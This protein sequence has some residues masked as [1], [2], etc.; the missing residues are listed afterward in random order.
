MAWDSSKYTDVNTRITQF[1][2]LY[3]NGRIHTEIVLINEQQ[4]VIK[5][6]AYTD[7]D[8][9]RPASIDFAQES[10]ADRGVNSTSWV[11]NC[12]TSAIGR[13]LATLGFSPRGG[14]RASIEEMQKVVR[15]YQQKADALALAG[16][17]EGLR[18]LLADAEAN[19]A[20][21]DAVQHIIALG[22]QMKKA[23][24]VESSETAA[25]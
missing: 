23:A 11:E 6:S 10:V 22:Q 14:A 1:W 4:V 13:C 12:S 15:V 25:E 3:P 17:I 2:E 20:A 19:K 18:R 8:D 9:Q 24:S 21:A 7:R 16:D 5:A